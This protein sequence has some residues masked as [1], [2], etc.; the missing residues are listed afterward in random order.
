MPRF[1]R[2]Q[3]YLSVKSSQSKFMYTALQSK[4]QYL[5]TLQVSRYCLLALH[6]SMLVIYTLQLMTHPVGSNGAICSLL[7]L[8]KINI[9][10]CKITYRYIMRLDVRSIKVTIK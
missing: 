1:H 6:C 2:D 7:S 5:L 4:M 8:L 9:R 10:L 3:E